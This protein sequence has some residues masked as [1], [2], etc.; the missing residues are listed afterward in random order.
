M[1][2]CFAVAMAFLLVSCDE[3]RAGISSANPGDVSVAP[4]YD[5]QRKQ[6][7]IR[8]INHADVMVEIA[9]LNYMI[10]QNDSKVVGCYRVSLHPEDANSALV[11]LKGPPGEWVEREIYSGSEL[12]VA[13]RGRLAIRDTE[14]LERF[15]SDG[16]TKISVAVHLM[17]CDI[18]NGKRF[19]QPRFIKAKAIEI[20][21]P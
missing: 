8:V 12:W 21:K 20:L 6:I 2:I 7:V 9:A 16:V 17:I 19:G 4:E 1:K 3:G 18:V 13:Y 10:A 11:A 5:S 14:G 15:W